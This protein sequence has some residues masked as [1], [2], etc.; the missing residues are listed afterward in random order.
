MVW[1]GWEV[2]VGRLWVEESVGEGSMLGESGGV[3]LWRS[4]CVGP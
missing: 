1:V 2:V 3:L 4:E